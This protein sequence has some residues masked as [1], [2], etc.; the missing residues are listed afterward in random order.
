MLA[1]N[2]LSREA[3]LLKENKILSAVLLLLAVVIVFQGYFIYKTASNVK[4][5]VYPVG[6]NKKITISK[7]EIDREYLYYLARSIFSLYLSYTPNTIKEQ[8]EALLSLMSPRAVAK[9]KPLFEQIIEEVSA[10][11]LVSVFSLTKLELDLKRNRVIAK[12]RRIILLEGSQTV[13]DSKSEVYAF[14]FKVSNFR[15]EIEDIGLL[16]DLQVEEK[17]KEGEGKQGK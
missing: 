17:N 3:K 16:R 11:K 14:D 15:F 12:G 1:G 4:V 2:I 7:T 9:Y 5:V 6:Y 8:Y 13:V 10:G